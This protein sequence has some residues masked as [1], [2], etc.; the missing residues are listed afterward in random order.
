[1]TSR[2]HNA[3]AMLVAAMA[4][5]GAAGCTAPTSADV[6]SARAEIAAASSGR[7]TP[8]SQD[9]PDDGMQ[10]HCDANPDDPKCPEVP[11][12]GGRLPC[13]VCATAVGAYAY[14]TVA[15][16][17]DG[18]VNVDLRANGQSVV[19]A[20]VPANVANVPVK[21]PTPFTN[22]TWFEVVVLSPVVIIDSPD[23]LGD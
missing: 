20:A 16:A 21:L 22:G 9:V 5:T 18:Y 4:I 12:R 17:T 8:S 14:V 2:M 10:A 3:G 15:A 19:K 6:A 1:M 23:F 13:A 7:I 11:S